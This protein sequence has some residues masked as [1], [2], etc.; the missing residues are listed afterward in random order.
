[1]FGAK[2]TR[3]EHLSSNSLTS[4]A[5]LFL[6]PNYFEFCCI[7]ITNYIRLHASHHIRGL[8]GLQVRPPAT[9]I[10]L[11]SS[12]KFLNATSYSIAGRHQ[13]L[14]IG[15]ETHWAAKLRRLNKMQSGRWATASHPGMCTLSRNINIAASHPNNS[16][17]S[18]KWPCHMYFDV[19][20]ARP[21]ALNSAFTW[22]RMLLV[23]LSPHTAG[24]WVRSRL[25]WPLA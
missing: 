12:P 15:I 14:S 6:A 24:K 22:P 25:A 18:F 5:F 8:L 7:D 21:W 23:L 11:K 13:S 3:T 10:W 2:I 17:R 1:M 16:S 20:C 19:F 9:R 4:L